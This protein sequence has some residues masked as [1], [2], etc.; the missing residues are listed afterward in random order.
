MKKKAKKTEE[1]I[2]YN[3]YSVYSTR[4][5]MGYSVVINYEEFGYEKKTIDLSSVL[6]VSWGEADK[7]REF[8]EQFF[9]GLPMSILG[10]GSQI[11][12]SI[13]AHKSNLAQLERKTAELRKWIEQDEAKLRIAE[14]SDD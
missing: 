8:F 13:K 11:R 1:P 14:N 5:G 6:D 2:F 12:R 4:A 9:A 10:P 3:P 7:I